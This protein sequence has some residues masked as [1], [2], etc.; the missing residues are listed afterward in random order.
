MC[1]YKISN[2][3]IIQMEWTPLHWAASNSHSDS[4]DLLASRGADIYMKDGVS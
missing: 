4:V 3:F 2:N 1:L